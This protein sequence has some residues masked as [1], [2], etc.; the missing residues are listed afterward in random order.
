MPTGSFGTRIQAMVSY[1]GGRFGLS[2]REMAELMG[3]SFHIEMSLGSI[4]AQEQR[5]SAALKA[6]VEEAVAFV[7]QQVSA[8]V[9][10]TGW[11]KR[12]KPAWL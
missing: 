6:P 4:P 10:E 1:L 3:V 12:G 8:N 7:G 5:L 11:H 9:D 2:Q